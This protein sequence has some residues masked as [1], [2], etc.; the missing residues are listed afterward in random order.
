MHWRRRLGRGYDHARVLAR[1]V[2]GRL[3][4]P[5]GAELVRVRHTAPQVNLPATRR[6]ENVRGAFAVGDARAVAA[7]DVLLVDDVTTTGATANEA[8]RTLLAAGAA[9]VVLAV[10]AKAEPPTAYAP[11]LPSAPLEISP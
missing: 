6:I 9:R 2:G 7:A 5:V 3:D 11:H 8:A 1:E 4:V 10:V